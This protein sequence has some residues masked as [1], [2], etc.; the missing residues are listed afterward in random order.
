M[1]LAEST[2]GQ[3]A[4]HGPRQ[5]RQSLNSTALSGRPPARH[6]N[7]PGR[8]RR[9]VNARQRAWVWG[10]SCRYG[11]SRYVRVTGRSPRLARPRRI[12]GNAVTVPECPRCRLT[13]DPGRVDPSTADT[14][15]PGP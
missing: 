14:I 3:H 6:P 9:T 13:I 15:A 5:S 4:T 11:E 7:H 12:A 10:G 2:R 8:A 1:V